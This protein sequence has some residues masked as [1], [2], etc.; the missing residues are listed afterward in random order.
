MKR[1]LLLVTLLMLSLCSLLAQ[2]V[3]AI[4][5]ELD[6]IDDFGNDDFSALYTIVSQKPGERDNVT[7]VRIF[8]RDRLNLFTMLVILP[9]VNKGQGY[10][11]E[12]NNVWFYDPV[13]RKFSFSSI[14][15]NI[16]NSEA[17][18]SDLISS[19]LSDNYNV[20]A[21]SE[22]RVGS[23]AVWI[24]ELEA[25]TSDVP[26]DRLK[27]Y[28]R[29]DQIMLLKEEA[30]SVSGRLLRTSLFPRYA[31]IGG[32]LVPSQLLI[33]D[34]LNPGERSQITMT[35]QSIATLPDR[36]FSKAY[37]EQVNR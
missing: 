20:I 9:E 12:D 35:E 32:R 10:L 37:L 7:Q 3:T 18:N 11:R 17:K 22:G 21:T 14:Q 28:V 5:A 16:Q 31:N 29:K 1:L 8:R 26:Y 27:L 15:E 4:L 13:S 2:D 25:K 36:V 23:I 19:K 34:E 6:Q 24:L 33:I 30:F